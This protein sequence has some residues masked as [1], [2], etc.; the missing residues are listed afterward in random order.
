[1]YYLQRK[2]KHKN[3][4]IISVLFGRWKT[5]EKFKYEKHAL[6]TLQECNDKNVFNLWEYRIW[7]RKKGGREETIDCHQRKDNT[8]Q[9]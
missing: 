4:S 3:D 2:Y 7:T 8:Q 6:K 1:M 9:T 5:I